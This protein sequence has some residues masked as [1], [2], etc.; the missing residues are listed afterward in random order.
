MSGRVDEISE[1]QIGIHVF[2]RPTDYDPGTDNIVRSQARILRRKLEEYFA[3]EGR[4]EV[5]TLTVPRGGYVPAFGARVG[6][7][8]AE[9][10]AGFGMRWR[11]VLAI[12]AV[13]AALGAGLWTAG[14]IAETRISHRLWASL[15][16]SHQ[17]T[18]IVPADSSLV[19]LQNLTERPVT[20]AEYS[21]GSYKTQL[22][23]PHGVGA[24]LLRNFAE[25]QYTS[26]ADVKL[27]DRF[28]REFRGSTERVGIRYCRFARVE[29]FKS[30]NAVLIGVKQ[31]NPWVE[32]FEGQMNFR[33]EYAEGTSGYRV[34]N[35]KPLAG[36]RKEYVNRPDDPQRKVYASLAVVRNLTGTGRVLI[37]QG[38]TMAGTE[39]AADF[40]FNDRGLEG[41]LG[42]WDPATYLELFLESA[43]LGNNAKESRVVSVRRW[44]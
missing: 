8:S 21:N 7:E 13:A 38:T 9:V 39:A 10:S 44:E 25:R 32:L 30:G 5:L 19:L 14:R 35:H 29:D 20:L 36:E 2:R 15:V 37:V 28:L 33:F 43:E 22:P 26:M 27:I 41:A 16:D 1:Q 23:S 12:G 24:E 34:I 31:A 18:W 4:H 6:G 3:E 11:W 42:K 17:D 40:A